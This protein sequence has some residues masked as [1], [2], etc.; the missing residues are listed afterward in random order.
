MVLM[1]A[2]GTCLP[3]SVFYHAVHD[4][5]IKEE[6]FHGDRLASISY[7]LYIPFWNIGG[8]KTSAAA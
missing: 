4:E 6:N 3:A 5:R 2:V 7:M 1:P 8:T